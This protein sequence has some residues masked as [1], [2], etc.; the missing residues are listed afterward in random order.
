M[1]VTQIG[2]ELERNARRKR[3]ASLVGFGRALVS[4]V[5]AVAMPSNDDVD[6]ILNFDVASA[7]DVAS[8]F[9]Y[10]RGVGFHF[11]PSSS[12]ELF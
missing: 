3:Y 8:R 4:F 9:V 6:L 10:G 5:M 11:G 2:P 1:D 7:V 12:S